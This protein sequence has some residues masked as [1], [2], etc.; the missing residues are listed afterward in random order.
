LINL[1]KNT[2]V[3]LSYSYQEFKEQCLAKTEGKE[4]F[5]RHYAGSASG[6][7]NNFHKH[8]NDSFMYIWCIVE[9]KY[10]YFEIVYNTI[11]NRFLFYLKTILGKMR[12][13]VCMHE[14]EQM[15]LKILIESFFEH[16]E[17]QAV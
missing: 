8:Q 14:A 2:P 13:E 5:N 15:P 4:L 3:L 7:S 12:F 16:Y 11:S 10:D 17:D 1:K 9:N 6:L